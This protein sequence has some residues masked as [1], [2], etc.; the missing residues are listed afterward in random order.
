MSTIVAAALS[1][2]LW[3]AGSGLH[4][5]PA[6]TWLAPLPLL[7]LAVP[8]KALTATLVAWPIGQLGLA[9]YFIRT[10]QI[11]LPVVIAFV[12]YGTA[13]AA[14]TV[15]L[16]V[17]LLRRGR[18]GTAVLAAPALWV[19][20]EYL[21]TLALPNGAWWSL[22]YTQADVRPV[23]QLTA[24]TGV[25]GVSYLLV[26]VPIGLAALRTRPKPALACLLA[27]AV[28]AGGWATWSLT[29]VPDAAAELRVGLVALEQPED[30]MP[31]GEA[32][33]R[34]L[35]ARYVARVESLAE[36]GA[37]IVVLPEKVFGVDSPAALAEAFRPVTARG[38][39]VVAG[40]VQGQRNVAFVLGGTVRTYTKQH[41]IKGLEDWITPGDRDLIVDGRY[42]VAI[43]KDLDF[44][45]LVRGYRARGA[46]MMLVPALDF[47]GD[48]WLH[49][50]MA[51]V[52]GV[53]S[54][55]TVVRAA[56]FGRLT[57][58]DPTGR[59]LGEATAGDADLL[60]TV[61]PSARGTVY[62]RTG[63]WFVLLSVLLL[64]TAV[65][66]AAYRKPAIAATADR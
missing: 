54:G 66:R 52:R 35:L 29:R 31:L 20:G 33:G 24:L 64:V 41:V 3:L 12:L 28:T 51:V 1:G 37:R 2:L 25:W 63:N 7:L 44:P 43:C 38:V 32:A 53:E 39:Q 55:T 4:P 58:S 65:V 8:R 34:E 60:V 21:V 50:R 19:L 46:T 5:V 15:V 9:G 17:T 40:A 27:L 26:A 48:G 30:G 6:L 56:G 45:E 59:V 22:A 23:V 62:G 47:T 49:S 57:V 14:G 61:T 11:P 10:L 13:L 36:R 42:G 16:A 18:T